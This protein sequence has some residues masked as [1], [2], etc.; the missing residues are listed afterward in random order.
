MESRQSSRDWVWYGGRP[1][2]DFVNTLRDRYRGG[3]E[4][5]LEPDDLTAWFAAAGQH[6][7]PPAGDPAER[8]AVDEELLARAVRLR[9]AVDDGLRAVVDGTR[10]PVEAA[11]V[12]NTWLA[13]AADH[14]PRLAVHDGLPT[15][16][17][18]RR[19]ADATTALTLIAV[20][21]AEILGSEDR[22]RLK[23][24][25]GNGCSGRYYD[26]SPACR[27]RWCSMSGCGNRA[28]AA[29]HRQRTA[30]P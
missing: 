2:V 18:T 23:I 12:I 15:L 9:E 14:P 7:A 25:T 17:H 10:F 11:E 19:P 1:S 5:L 3:R 28:K 4:L 8:L 26:K 29:Q 13:R 24:C 21:A 27:R 6:T 20:D 30:A 22:R 16:R